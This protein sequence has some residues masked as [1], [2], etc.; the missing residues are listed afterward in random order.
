MAARL[1]NK[2]APYLWTPKE[3]LGHASYL[4]DNF[5]FL[6]GK[7][8]AQSSCDPDL[9]AASWRILRGGRMDLRRAQFRSEVPPDKLKVV[10][11]VD[12]LS[13]AVARQF[14]LIYRSD[15]KK[16]T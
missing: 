14:K 7:L 1:G 6:K 15:I 12:A 3:W 16:Q 8:K 5:T 11:E 4:R 2:L 13:G 10:K 9:I